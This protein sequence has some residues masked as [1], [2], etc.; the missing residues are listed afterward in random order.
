M[1]GKPSRNPESVRDDSSKAQPMPL[2]I[3]PLE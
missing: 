1:T 3:I 2:K